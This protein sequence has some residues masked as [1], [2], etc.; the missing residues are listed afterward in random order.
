[1]ENLITGFRERPFVSSIDTQILLLPAIVVIRGILFSQTMVYIDPTEFI[2]RRRPTI[3]SF[4]WALWLRMPQKLRMFIYRCAIRVGTP[5]SSYQVMRLPFGLYVKVGNKSNIMEGLAT[6]YVSMNTFIPVPNI[7]DIAKDHVGALF[8]MT[9]VPGT[10]VSEMEDG[11]D[12]ASPEQLSVFA[13]TMRDWLAQLQSLTPPN[14]G[15]ICGLLGGEFTSYR[16][17]CSSRVGPFESQ[18]IF[19]GKMFCT[20]QPGA[21]PAIVA[22]A[23]SGRQKRYRMCFTHGDLS[24]DN[25]LVDDH[26]RPVGL[27]DWQCAAP[28]TGISRRLCGIASAS[29]HGSMPLSRCFR[30][31]LAIEMELWKT[32]CPF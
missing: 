10:P 2:Y 18:D 23:Q 5:T 25:I 22:L 24:P 31:E 6:H 29:C 1:M 27:V 20:L 17:D 30:D 26:F 3:S 28:N 21:D 12:A 15:S 7:L 19:H 4:M 9:R 11:L 13:N 8:L 32:I 14:D 16:I